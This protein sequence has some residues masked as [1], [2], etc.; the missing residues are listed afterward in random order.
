MA[1]PHTAVY[2]GLC[3]NYFQH[4]PIRANRGKGTRLNLS[5]VT[6]CIRLVHLISNAI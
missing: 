3:A 6:P 1:G 5:R 2:F 4:C